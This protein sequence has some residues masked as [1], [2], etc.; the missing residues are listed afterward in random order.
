[1]LFTEADVIACVVHFA[2]PLPAVP[3]L[4]KNVAADAV[5]L[6]PV[7][8]LL[9]VPLL[10]YSDALDALV[11]PQEVEADLERLGHAAHHLRL[12]CHWEHLVTS[13]PAAA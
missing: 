11:H 1:M 12:L 8:P 3:P 9:R 2:R 13:E 7:L 6:A 5:A 4:Q 10:E